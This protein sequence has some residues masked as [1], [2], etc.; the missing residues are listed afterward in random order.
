MEK[1]IYKQYKEIKDR[2]AKGEPTTF[3]ERNWFNIIEKK[4]LK[5]A[6]SS[7]SGVGRLR[8]EGDG[9]RNPVLPFLI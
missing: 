7:T 6:R 5:K 2:I 1:A 8:G 4:K 9:H 3:K